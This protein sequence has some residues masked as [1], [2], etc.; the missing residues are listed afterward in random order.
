MPTPLPVIETLHVTPL[1]DIQSASFATSY[2]QG[3]YWSLSGEREVNDPLP[4]SY[5]VEHLETYITR[6]YF[7]GKHE[8]CLPFLGFYLGMVHGGVLTDRGKLRPDVTTLVVLQQR[9][10]TRGYHAGREW[11]FYEASP[12]ERWQTESDLIE[13]LREVAR[14]HLHFRDQ[15]ATLRYAFG[16]V[17]GELSGHLF[18]KTAQETQAW[19]AE[20]QQARQAYEQ[21]QVHREQ[22]HTEPL[23]IRASTL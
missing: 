17:L 2:A 6:G 8:H 5:F 1:L 13:R 3:L 14:E 11:Y 22:S 12:R 7:E 19:E 21:E 4:E 23:S 10:T 18:P 20:W 9:Q 16:C 15:Q